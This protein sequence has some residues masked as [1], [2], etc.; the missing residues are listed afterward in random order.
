M[1]DAEMRRAMGP[2]RT[3]WWNGQRKVAK[4]AK[5]S[6]HTLAIFDFSQHSGGGMLPGGNIET[7][8]ADEG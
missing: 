5:C 2:I 7:A 1:G 8:E 3:G 4:I 6:A